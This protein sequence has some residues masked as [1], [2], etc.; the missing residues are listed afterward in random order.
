MHT[1]VRVYTEFYDCISRNI[2][3]Y[4]E[5]SLCTA[6]LH[7]QS[8]LSLVQPA[9]AFDLLIVQ[10]KMWMQKQIPLTLIV[11]LID[12]KHVVRC[13]ESSAQASKHTRGGGY[14]LQLLN[15]YGYEY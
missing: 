11:G 5:Q 7:L 8:V 10:A 4:H 12:N 14:V 9:N 6:R 15:Y 2:W 13:Q 1:Y 3:S